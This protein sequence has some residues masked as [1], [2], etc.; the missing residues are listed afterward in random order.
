LCRTD[1]EN[2][3]DCIITYDTQDSEAELLMA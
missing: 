3:V 2:D 1:C